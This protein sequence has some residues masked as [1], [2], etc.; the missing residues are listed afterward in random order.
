MVV[1][2]V[3]SRHGF[4]WP[5]GRNNEPLDTA[6]QGPATSV[7][8]GGPKTAVLAVSWCPVK[9]R[10]TFPQKDLAPIP[11]DKTEVQGPVS[12]EAAGKVRGGTRRHGE[13]YRIL[14][15]SFPS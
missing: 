10:I 11:T 12:G 8:C 1:A 5:L 3:V 14:Q 9:V 6:A 15:H 4:Q 13:R 7:A 2:F